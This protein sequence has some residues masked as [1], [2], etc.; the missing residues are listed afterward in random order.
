MLEP[1]LS[2]SSNGKKTNSL[3]FCRTDCHTCVSLGQACDRRRPQCSTCLSQGRKCGGFATPLSWATQRM[4]T[5]NPLAKEGA[6]GHATQPVSSRNPRKPCSP[7][8]FRFVMGASKP[9]KRRKAPNSSQRENALVSRSTLEDRPPSTGE[10]V[11]A[12]AGEHLQLPNNDQTSTYP[13]DDLGNGDLTVPSTNSTTFLN[14][15]LNLFD[16]I[17][18]NSFDPISFP[19]LDRGEP[20]T[21]EVSN[22][23][24]TLSTTPPFNAMEDT[25]DNPPDNRDQLDSFMQDLSSTLAGSAQPNLSNPM[26]NDQR[27][28]EINMPYGLSPNNPLGLSSIFRNDHDNLLQMCKIYIN[29]PKRHRLT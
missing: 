25:A 28:H 26:R 2:V 14:D 17:L 8:Q 4:W 27:I 11:P 12:T 7:R 23:L 21:A 1:D 20:S 3:A 24:I 16:S 9:R 15:D 22:N 19:G 29:T 18:P 13:A 5:D 10:G 6:G